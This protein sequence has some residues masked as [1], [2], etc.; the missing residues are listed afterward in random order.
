MA[1][2]PSALDGDLRR[3]P[4]IVACGTHSVNTAANV[5]AGAQTSYSGRQPPL[6][7][8][9]CRDGWVVDTLCR[10][11]EHS[12]HCGQSINGHIVPK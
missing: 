11:C 2:A 5:A 6:T 4:E 7:E 12:V 8:N 3:R 9:C 1:R 10:A